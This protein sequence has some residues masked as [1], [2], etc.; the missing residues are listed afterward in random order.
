M[1]K[2]IIMKKI[3]IG[4]ALLTSVSSFA[5]EIITAQS[6]SVIR[7]GDSSSPNRVVVGSRY[8][9]LLTH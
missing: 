9:N 8:K 6:N 3:L 4:L 5:L 7:G 1:K 2:E